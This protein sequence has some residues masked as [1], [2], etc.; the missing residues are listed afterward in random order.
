MVQEIVSSGNKGSTPCQTSS[1]RLFVCVFAIT[2]EGR[3]ALMRDRRRGGIA[4]CYL[5]LTVCIRVLV[6][7]QMGIHMCGGK[8][9]TIRSR[10]RVT[11]HYV[12]GPRA[13]DVVQS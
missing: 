1:I 4:L 6:L 9:G 13:T 7:D 11:G 3:N 10:W 2:G 12:L 8:L 5:Y